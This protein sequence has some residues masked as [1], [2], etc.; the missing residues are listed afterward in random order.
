M[1]TQTDQTP[2]FPCPTGSDGGIVQSGM[3]LRDYFAAGIAAKI[4]AGPEAQMVGARD[5]R[6]NGKDGWAKVVAAN[7]YEMADALIEQRN[8]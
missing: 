6:Y 5:Q 8:K 2:A 3:T 7:A 1:K 4:F